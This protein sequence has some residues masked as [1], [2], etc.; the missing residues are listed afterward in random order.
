MLGS[1]AIY[2]ENKRERKAIFLMFYCLK[3]L[4]EYFL[5]CS[6]SEKKSHFCF[7]FIDMAKKLIMRYLQM[8]CD[9][10]GKTRKVISFEG[11]FIHSFHF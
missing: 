11:T 8:R 3:K 6:W 5:N 7:Y 9:K 10:A 2:H 4:L 1:Q